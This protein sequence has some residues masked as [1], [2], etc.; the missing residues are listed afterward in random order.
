MGRSTGYWWAPD[1]RHIAYVRVDETPVKITQ[2]FEIAADNVATFDQ[3]Y[4]P[5][6]AAPTCWYGLGVTDVRTGAT[7]FI[8]LGSDPDIYLARVNWLPDG[9]NPGHSAREPGPAPPRPAIR[10][11]QDRSQPCGLDRNQRDV[12][13]ASRRTLVP[14]AIPPIHLGG[15]RRDGFEQPLSVR[16]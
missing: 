14:Q 10:G 1:D 4:H 3:R 12:D 5:R 11:H 9:K 8:D 16:L 6:R 2:R 7:T 15:P 13:R